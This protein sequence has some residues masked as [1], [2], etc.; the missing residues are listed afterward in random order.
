[1]SLLSRAQLI[2][3]SPS[4]DEN[5]RN[6]SDVPPTSQTPVKKKIQFSSFAQ[7]NKG[8]QQNA[9]IL[10]LL[11]APPVGTKLKESK[12][13]SV[14]EQSDVSQNSNPP[15]INLSLQPQDEDQQSIEKY[16]QKTA[17]NNEPDEETIARRNA[18]QQMNFAAKSTDLLTLAS[19]VLKENQSIMPLIEQLTTK[20]QSVSDDIQNRTTVIIKCF[21]R[22]FSQDN[23]KG[24][25]G[26]EDKVRFTVQED[27][28][29]HIESSFDNLKKFITKV[30]DIKA[31][32][33]SFVEI[34][35]PQFQ[36]KRALRIETHLLK[37]RKSK[38]LSIYDKV[39]SQVDDN[40]I[41]M[42]NYEK[43]ITD[44]I[45]VSKQGNSELLKF[46][47]KFQMRKKLLSVIK[48][49]E[50][51]ICDNYVF[52]FANPSCVLQKLSEDGEIVS[53]LA[54]DEQQILIGHSNF[55]MISAFKWVE[56]ERKYVQYFSGQLNSGLNETNIHLTHLQWSIS[57]KSQVYMSSQYSNIYRISCIEQ[58][59][60][61]YPQLEK[62]ELLYNL[63]MQKLIDF[64]EDFSQRLLILTT[65]KL[66]VLDLK[67]LLPVQQ[68]SGLQIN[69]STLA[70]L[71]N[72]DITLR[73]MVVAQGKQ[74][75]EIRDMMESGIHT[76]PQSVK[77]LEGMKLI[78]LLQ[79]QWG[80]HKGHMVF[81]EGITNI[82]AVQNGEMCVIAVKAR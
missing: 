14:S 79:G 18:K 41:V 16:V 53:V 66:V 27:I 60:L 21:E 2:P 7:M 48:H 63:K 82:I 71:T 72:F 40:M 11:R 46:Q 76:T 19:Q 3:D 44:F 35:L 13:V 58:L 30:S 54:L 75:I 56:N 68:Y 25:Y 4:D 64:K 22:M 51:M 50:R 74:G 43:G 32:V 80:G 62:K 55:S 28:Q 38:S 52:D 23:P 34:P 29:L 49:G 31:L 12:R 67:T 6:I 10:D 59:S 37:I 42:Q 8:K 17:K 45:N 5:S 47:V 33:K 15:I 77:G 73:P 78:G 20:L 1:M 61:I 70:T 24:L 65:K 69:Q 9:S 36:F 57:N 39:V 81:G 26:L